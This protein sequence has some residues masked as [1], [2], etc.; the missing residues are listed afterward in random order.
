[1]LATIS[2]TR[3]PTVALKCYA[4]N[5]PLNHTDPTGTTQAGNPLTNLFAGGYSGGVV[6]SPTFVNPYVGSTSIFATPTYNPYAAPLSNLSSP[7]I[8][9]LR[10][11]S[12]PNLSAGTH[13]NSQNVP[14]KN[15][16]YNQVY[17][18]LR[19]NI[20]ELGGEVRFNDPRAKSLLTGLNQ[21][22]D[23]LLVG[24]DFDYAE[25]RKLFENIRNLNDANGS[26][27]DKPRVITA[28]DIDYWIQYSNDLRQNQVF[29]FSQNHPVLVGTARDVTTNLAYGTI[30]TQGKFAEDLRQVRNEPVATTD[31][32]STPPSKPIHG[33]SLDYVGDTHVY[34]VKG[35]DGTYKIGESMQGT[36]VRDGASI[37]A[38]QQVRELNRT[39]GPGHTSEIRRVFPDKAS[40]RDY[41]TRL[42]DR[43]RRMFGDDT[44]PGNVTNR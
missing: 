31:A 25:S 40:A 42:I 19:A 22:V 2:T 41:E 1:M 37:R 12:S 16:E 10:P 38:E 17:D 13:L 11:A 44:L 27:I 9:Q 33:N 6:A 34:R 8:T 30:I 29:K 15:A 43:F 4:D 20:R 7:I 36:R 24:G 23:P 26:T 18:G 21:I 32:P 5:P 35:P 14:F 3:R 39:V 28:Q